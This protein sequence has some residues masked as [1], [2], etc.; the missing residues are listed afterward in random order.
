[1]VSRHLELSVLIV[2]DGNSLSTKI[3]ANNEVSLL[4]VQKKEGNLFL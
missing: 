1:M 2:S 3:R 4:F